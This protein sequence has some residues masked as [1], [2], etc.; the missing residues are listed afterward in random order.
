LAPL[1]LALLHYPV[2]DRE[3]NA[4]TTS[5]TNID[6]HDIARSARTYSAKNFFVVTP[7]A[8]QQEVLARIIEHWD[9]GAGKSRIPERSIAIGRVCIASA[10]DE[11]VQIIEKQNSAKPIVIATSAQ[12]REE[13]EA[14]TFERGRSELSNTERPVLLIFGTGHGLHDEVLRKVDVILEPIA[15]ESDF[16]HLSVRAAAAIVL[17][18]LCA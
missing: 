4:V 12:R 8:K 11:V 5:I 16:N 3:G 2:R 13:F 9:H 17:D 14:W 10:F 18:R 6:V 1:Y 7:I 15:P